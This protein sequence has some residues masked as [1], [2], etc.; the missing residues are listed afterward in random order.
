M[1]KTLISVFIIL[2]FT[3]GCKNASK[4]ENLL[5]ENLNVSAQKSLHVDFKY[6]PDWYV[7][8]ICLPDDS[9]K[10]LVGPLGQILY[11]YEGG[12]FQ[13]EP[14]E[15]FFPYSNNRGFKTVVHILP[16]E[17]I[18]FTG[19]ELF[20][21]KVPIV[22]TFGEINGLSVIQETFS[23]SSD[24]LL[25]FSEKNNSKLSDVAREDIILTTIQNKTNESRI[26]EPL[27]IINSEFPVIVSENVI[28]I[29]KR[30]LYLSHRII[31]FR[32]N[33]G[34]FKTIAELEPIIIKANEIKEIAVVYDN[35][36]PTSIVK[37][38]NTRPDEAIK[39]LRNIKEMVI[40]YWE[41][42]SP[43][44]A[45]SIL[46]PDKGIQNLIDASLRNIWQAR[47]VKNGSL[48]FQVGPTCYR[49]LWTV[50]GAF[51]LETATMVNKGLDARDGIEYMLSFQQPD[52]KFGR[53]ESNFWKEN[54]IVLW[55]CVRHAILTQ[56]KG[57]LKSI[58]PKLSKTVSFIKHLRETTLE[59]EFPLDDGLIPP[60]YIDGGLD[61]GFPEYTNVYWNLLGLKAMLQA[62]A[63]L[64]EKDDLKEW[65]KEYDDFYSVFQKAAHRDMVKDSYGNIYLPIP[66]DPKDHSLP[67]RAQWAFCQAVYPGQIFTQ[68]D[69]IAKGTL[70]M[71]HTTLQEGMVMGTGWIID[72]IWNYFASF[73]G[74]AC[75]WM[76]EGQRAAQSLYA[77]ANHASPLLAWREEINPRD[78]ER[79]FVGDMPHNWASAEFIRLA[80]HLLQVDRGNE[81]HLFE[82]LPI[83]WTRA[84]M[85]TKL[86]GIATPFGKLNMK[87]QISEDGEKARLNL[88][89]LSDSSCEKVVV[90]LGRWAA[91]DPNKT[92]ILDPEKDHN[93]EIQIEDLIGN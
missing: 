92:L 34:E 64:E 73:Y 80:V 12:V 45:N 57:W 63:W 60:G 62:A 6:A 49:G 9:L 55:I 10:T 40:R 41:K 51:I 23:Y 42:E 25:K 72:G 27:L 83:E 61:G 7:T 38:F 39:S 71:L 59:N 21:P 26:L 31:N 20:S 15:K 11:D 66:M 37:D 43:V 2:L 88:I 53:L 28:M 76:G 16:D 17:Q 4:D 90:H 56:D 32:Q 79:H 13:N 8:N 50:D 46:I 19:Q 82:G 22:K 75:L 3:I 5:H 87:L 89:S 91:G 85:V 47:E 74:H 14:G 86:D 68:D 1:M 30:E 58:W 33:L 48:S 70:D 44:P 24:G 81:L 78:L 77:F 36:K 52:G 65:Q 35:G 84:G 54:G 67:Q 93:I 29:D 18:K 69:P